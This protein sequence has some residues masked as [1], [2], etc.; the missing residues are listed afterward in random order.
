MRRQCRS[1]VHPSAFLTTLA[2]AAPG[3]AASACWR[4]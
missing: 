1:T 3:D 4:T 2:F